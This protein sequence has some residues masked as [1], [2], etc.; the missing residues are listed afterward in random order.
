MSRPRP[1]GRDQSSR[2][3]R[4]RAHGAPRTGADAAARRPYQWSHAQP[5]SNDSTLRRPWLDSLEVARAF[6]V[7]DRVI[8]GLDL[9]A[10]G[11]HVKINHRVTKGSPGQ[12]APVEQVGG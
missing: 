12:L 7:R 1:S 10:R 9:Q 3:R 4:G 11:M 6:P 5:D 2:T 8:E